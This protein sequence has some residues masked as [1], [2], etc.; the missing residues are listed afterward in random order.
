MA[1]EL[2][3]ECQAYCDHLNELLAGYELAA[4]LPLSP[5]NLLPRLRDGVL[6]THVLHYLYPEAV[7]VDLL[8]RGIDMETHGS[9]AGNQTAVFEAT[10]N[11]NRALD[12]ARQAKNLVVVNIG[13]QDILEMK[14]DLVL[15][16]LWQLIRSQ[17]LGRINLLSHPELV[18]LLQPGESLAALAA[19]RPEP[20]LLRWFNHHLERSG[21]ACR[22]QSLARDVASGEA[23]LRLIHAI[24]ADCADAAFDLDAALG[25]PDR[26]AHVLQWARQL[27]STTR[28]RPEDIASGHPRLNLAFTAALFNSHVGIHL[29]S[30]E[31]IRLMLLEIS[32][33]RRRVSDLGSELETADVQRQGA[34]EAL[35]RENQELRQQM[36]ALRTAQVAE[37][38]TIE[39]EFAGYRD[40][41]AEEYNESLTEAIASERRVHQQELGEARAGLREARRRLLGQLAEAGPAAHLE[42][43]KAGEMLRTLDPEEASLEQLVMVQGALCRALRD[44]AAALAQANARLTADLQGKAQLEAVMAAKIKEYSEQRI[45]ASEQQQQHRPRSSSVSSS[46]R[47][48][49]RA[50]TCQL[51]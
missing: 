9:E 18:R 47:S 31:E 36:A 37:L 43:T 20:L 5:A 10:A 44:Q 35:H 19:L 41:I 24:S 8:I 51:R 46:L 27:G 32:G 16:L 13:A 38:R 48:I 15:G 26:L 23:Y 28:I 14:E 4:Y 49:R 11:L 1:S 7:R 30:E 45:L 12:A 40:E 25:S 6:L 33:L 2:E 42:G 29:P 21:A 3:R 34:V 22:V 17:L 39:A 50:F